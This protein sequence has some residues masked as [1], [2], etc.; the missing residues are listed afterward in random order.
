MFNSLLGM[1]SSD[2]AI[3]LGTANTLVYVKGRGIVLNEPSVV[4]FAVKNGRK[5]VLAVGE[6]AK[7]MLGRTPGSIQAIRPMRDGVIADFDV[8]EEMIKHFIRKVHRRGSFA[9]P[10]II[11]CV[12][13][14][15]T[16]VEERAIR[17]SVLSAGARKAALIPE[18][19]AAAIGAGMPIT[20]A[21]GNMVVDIGGGTTEV[22]VLSLGDIVYA[23]SI[24][25]GGDKMDEAIIAFLRRQQNIL[26]GESTAERIKTTIGTARMPDDGRGRSMEIRGRDLLN[27]VPKEI[28]VTQGQI[29]E[30]L[31]EPVMQIKEAVMSA[32]EATPPDLAADIVDRGVMLTGGGA[33]LGD[34]DLALREQTGLAIT[35]AEEPLSC[36]ALGTGKAL[37]HEKDLIHI[38]NY[39]R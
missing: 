21:T 37:E 29:A 22:A 18:P 2:M 39:D 19:I 24:R 17:E 25:V 15:A 8:A 12:P 13:Y 33:L 26:I 1:V 3:D 9:S 10:K 11:V 14:G 6:D 28:E 20:E 32:L 23:R 35:V 36:V 34:L 27:G 38:L 7:L 4:A 31:A 5:E 16:P 30:A